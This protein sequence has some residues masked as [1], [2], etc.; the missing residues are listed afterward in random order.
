MALQTTTRSPRAVRS[1]LHISVSTALLAT[2]VSTAGLLV[3]TTAV[4]EETEAET[5]AVEI[6]DKA[7]QHFKAGVNFLQDPDGARYEEAYGQFRAAYQESP[8]WKILGNLGVS[9]MKLEKDGEAIDAFEKYLAEGGDDIT[10]GERSQFSR[11]LDSLKASVVTIQLS[12]TPGG[13]KIVDER[14]TNRG[15]SIRNQ[16]TIPDSG[17][18]TIRVRAGSHKF[19][20]KL[21]GHE[22]N[23]WEV[24]AAAAS[25]LEHSFEM[26]KPETAAAPSAAPAAA[27][28]APSEGDQVTHR[29]VPLSVWIGAGATVAFAG[30][31]AAMGI[32]AT[33]KNGDYDTAN[34]FGDDDAADL[35]DDVKQFNLLADAFFG[36]A[37]VAGVVTTILYVTRPEVKEKAALQVRPLV[38]PNVAALGLTG[39]F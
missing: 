33:G 29:P 31:G 17:S 27:T 19:T 24:D 4:A 12:S 7:R 39:T 11:D 6:T 5:A 15:A 36:G 14:T 28:S 35:R 37:V 16:Y 23:V 3:A 26:A 2:A 8:S 21:S 22:N 20:A 13:T 9:A 30:A 25:S 18:L 38:G 32:V 10:D 34:E 1:S